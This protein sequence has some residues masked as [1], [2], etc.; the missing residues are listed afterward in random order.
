MFVQYIL[1][2][3]IF[4]VA[5]G[6]IAFG[7]C[8]TSNKFAVKTDPLYDKIK[9]IIGEVNCGACGYAGCAGYSKALSTFEDNLGK[10]RPMKQQGY[11][12]IQQILNEEKS[13]RLQHINKQE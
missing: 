13:K 3:L 12:Q 7:L 11:E 5:S 9:S 1:P 10:C 4:T 8:V 6:L 2:I